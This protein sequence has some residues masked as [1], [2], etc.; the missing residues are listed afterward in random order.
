V[1]GYLKANPN[2]VLREEFDDWALLFDPDTG[3][4]YALNPVGVIIWKHLTGERSVE[5]ILRL[6]EEQ[7]EG[8][9][10]DASEHIREF[11]NSVH[12]LG[13]AEYVERAP[14]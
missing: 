13:L 9:T 11:M 10:P 4:T 3:N 7:V 12:S 6:V 2:I 8:L 14:S 5:E 1:L